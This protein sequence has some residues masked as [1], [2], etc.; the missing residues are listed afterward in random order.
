MNTFI[1]NKNNDNNN[2]KQ[3]V[4]WDAVR[5]VFNNTQLLPAFTEMLI[6]CQL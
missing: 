3:L 6:S 1:Y 2:K 4:I 5:P